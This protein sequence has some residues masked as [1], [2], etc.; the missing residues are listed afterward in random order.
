MCDTPYSDDREHVMRMV[1]SDPN[2]RVIAGYADSQQIPHP[3]PGWSGR[4]GTVYQE[5]HLRPD[6]VMA[7]KVMA[8]ERVYC[9][10]FLD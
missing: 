1:S 7:L 2:A 4:S 6:E 3:C 8:A 9:R 10:Q 5:Q